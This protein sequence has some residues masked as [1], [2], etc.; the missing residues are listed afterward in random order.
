MLNY[1]K[2]N[3][4]EC[5]RLLETANRVLG[6]EKIKIE[7]DT[8]ITKTLKVEI[9]QTKLKTISQILEEAGALPNGATE[10]ADR[11]LSAKIN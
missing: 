2:K 1:K 7:T 11:I 5:R 9:T 6:F 3:F 8:K 10:A 4:S